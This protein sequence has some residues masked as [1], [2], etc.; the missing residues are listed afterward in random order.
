M[1]D[2]L[3]IT[4][5]L[6]LPA[7]ALEVS[8]SRAGGPGGQ[9][10]NKTETRVQISFDL[11]GCQVLPEAVKV[12]LR[13]QNPGRL[14][15][16]DRIVLAC[17]VHRERLQNLAEARARLAALVRAALHPPRPRRATR[18]PPSAKRKRLAAKKHRAALKQ[19]RG[20]PDDE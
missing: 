7:A 8:Y 3:P 13:C 4:D 1:P 16:D 14:T 6:T 10:V 20:R 2:D 17:D 5:T 11:A 18:M 9:K 19:Q 15:R 12:R